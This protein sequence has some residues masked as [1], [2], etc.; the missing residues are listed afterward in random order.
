MRVARRQRR[1]AEP[2]ALSGEAFG[3]QIDGAGEGRLRLETPREFVGVRGN[4]TFHWIPDKHDQ[5]HIRQ[6]PRDPRPGQR[7][8]QVVGRRLEG[9]HARPP[10]REVRPIPGQT[11]PVGHVEVVHALAQNRL[12]DL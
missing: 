9:Q 2:G 11:P 1:G 7:V 10:Q 3:L 8:E 12:G 5:L 4:G 6:I